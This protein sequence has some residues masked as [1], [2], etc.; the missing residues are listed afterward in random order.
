MIKIKNLIIPETELEYLREDKSGKRLYV[1]LKGQHDEITFYESL[2]EDIEFNYSEKSVSGRVRQLEA[3]LERR[4]KEHERKIKELESKNKTF[5]EYN[6]DLNNQIEKCKSSLANEKRMKE[7]FKNEL[8]TKETRI[9]KT[10]DEL[11]RF[12]K[13]D[14]APDPKYIEKL[15]KGEI[16]E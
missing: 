3:T 4:R 12:I 7:Y 13:M 10:I 14:V 16:Q 2:I 1:K 5:E 15:L 6:K 8:I 9:S 11:F